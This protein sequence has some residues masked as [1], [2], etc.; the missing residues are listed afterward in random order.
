M[1]DFLGPMGVTPY[2]LA[3]S[4]GVGRSGPS[5]V[6]ESSPDV[7]VAPASASLVISILRCAGTQS[8]MVT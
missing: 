3:K 7:T 2:R 6:I 5:T 8:T 4:I 1:E